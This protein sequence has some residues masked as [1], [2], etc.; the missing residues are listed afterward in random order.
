MWDGLII[1]I[2]II[3]E[4]E[5]EVSLFYTVKCIEDKNQC[6]EVRGGTYFS[7]R[8]LLPVSLNEFV[9]CFSLSLSSFFLLCFLDF[10]R[11]SW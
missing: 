5:D 7:V 10:G 8:L 6:I 11:C 3:E 9:F 4:E 2:I 1:I